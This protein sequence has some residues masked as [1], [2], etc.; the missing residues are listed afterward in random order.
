MARFLATPIAVLLSLA[1]QA[2][3]DDMAPIIEKVRAHEAAYDDFRIKFTRRYSLKAPTVRLETMIRD[4]EHVVDY[5][6]KGAKYRYRLEGFEDPVKGDRLRLDITR[7]SDGKDTRYLDGRAIANILHNTTAIDYEI[8]TPHLLL[9]PNFGVDGPLSRILGGR[10][11]SEKRRITVEPAGEEEVRG[12]PCQVVKIAHHRIEDDPD[13]VKLWLSV[14]QNHLPI[15][16]EGFNPEVSRT[17]P[18]ETG[19]VEALRE[20]EPGLWFPTA[21]SVVVYDPFELAKGRRTALGIHQFK[22]EA[23]TLRPQVDDSLFTELTI[24]DGVPVIEADGDR[25]LRRYV[26]GE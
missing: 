16:T 24:P 12:W 20:V 2:Y 21:S 3:G 13:V 19:E 26:Q 22:A 17:S 25:I 6:I 5:V 11:A 14:K 4:R 15:K 9:L 7:I 10:S 18:V 8:Y 1:S 23:I